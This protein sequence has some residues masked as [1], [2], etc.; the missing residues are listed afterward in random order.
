MT[1]RPDTSGNAGATAPET[2]LRAGG[3]LG[4][5][6]LEGER[7]P[8]PL[9]HEG[10]GAVLGL[11]LPSEQLGQLLLVLIRRRLGEVGVDR[12]HLGLGAL[13]GPLGLGHPVAQGL[14]GAAAALAALGFAAS[15]P[16]AVAAG[17]WRWRWR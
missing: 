8:L 14:R 2:G 1:A 9:G 16:R 10:G 15:L 17:R 3:V 4:F 13:P 11:A 12:H 7:G 6:S 5:G